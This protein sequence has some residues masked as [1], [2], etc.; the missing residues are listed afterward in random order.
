MTVG[1]DVSMLFPDVTNIMQTDNLELKKVRARGGLA[2]QGAS[3]VLIS[4]IGVQGRRT[5]CLAW[6]RGRRIALRVRVKDSRGA[7]EGIQRGELRTLAW[8]PP[9]PTRT[10]AECNPTRR[11]LPRCACKPFTQAL[12]RAPS[13]PS[14][15]VGVP[16]PD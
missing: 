10:R 2:P 3:V 12:T 8:R 16:V 15:A 14:P 9:R 7:L 1:K 11:E 6:R 13:S 4:Y 5:G